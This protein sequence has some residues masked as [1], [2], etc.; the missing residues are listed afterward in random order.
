L[1]FLAW[2]T[3]RVLLL[4]PAFLIGLGFAS[5]LSLSG[6]SAVDAGSSRWSE[7]ADWVHLSAA[8]LW[9]GGLVQLAFCLWPLAPELRREAFLRF[10][11]FATVLIAL[12]V[13]AGIYLSVLR[14][15]H[16]RDLW[17]AG[18]GHVLLVKLGLV[19][20]ALAWGAFH[21][22][23]ARPSLA[24]SGGDGVVGRLARSLVGESAVGM[25]VLLAAAV[26]VDS[27]PPPQRPVP[28]ATTARLSP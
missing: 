27:K 6:H 1:V 14:L 5:G 24:G 4:W 3:D 17:T 13:G 16:L 21:H 28:A 7:L 19:A 20:I 26:L 12:I 23:V 10:S 9:A 11:R 8:I 15:P 2:L 25:A 18:Y 22:F